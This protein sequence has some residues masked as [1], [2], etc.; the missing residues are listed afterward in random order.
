M[1]AA[2]DASDRRRAIG[3]MGM[4]ER[5]A[6]VL[7]P[8]QLCDEALWAAQIEEMADIADFTVAD[9]TR[10]DSVE[11]M[12]ERALAAVS[13]PRLAVAGLSLGGYVALQIMR[14]APQRVARLA[15]I[16]TSAR[17][18]DPDQ[19][20]RRQRSVRA[21]QIG[22]FRGVTPRFLPGIIHSD[23][24]ADPAKARRVLEMTERVGK[25]AFERQQRAAMTRPE[26]RPLLPHIR[27]PTLVIG[28]RED[29]VIPPER[30]EEIA[31]AISGARLALLTP[32]GHLAPIEQPDAVSRLMREWLGWPT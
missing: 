2:A 12:A 29:R 16:S 15:L 31:G 20:L 6:V 18:D 7:L 26:S 27:C 13:A 23:H 9:L 22:A 5:Q 21:A 10:D 30:Q 4:A 17:A 24:V 32:C 28:G 8:G 11:A 1:H 3:E 19:T 14:R 25:M